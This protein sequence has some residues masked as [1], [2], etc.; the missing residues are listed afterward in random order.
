MKRRL[1]LLSSYKLHSSTTPFSYQVTII[2][3]SRYRVTYFNFD[4]MKIDKFIQISAAAF[5]RP[6]SC[7]IISSKWRIF[8]IIKFERIENVPSQSSGYRHN[9]FISEGAA[10]EKKKKK[11]GTGNRKIKGAEECGISNEDL[12]THLTDDSGQPQR[13]MREWNLDRTKKNIHLYKD[14]STGKD[15]DLKR[16]NGWTGVEFLHTFRKVGFE[17]SSYLIPFLLYDDHRIV[18]DPRN[19]PIKDDRDIPSTLSSKVEG[20]L[21]TLKM[22]RGAMATNRSRPSQDNAEGRR[23]YDRPPL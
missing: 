12:T 19:H 6:R 18:L 5:A 10:D 16:D 9:E 3:L 17:T 8:R 21:N 2:Q 14:I 4:W 13:N 23:Q 15:W 22:K 20:G 1:M 7:Y 11:Q